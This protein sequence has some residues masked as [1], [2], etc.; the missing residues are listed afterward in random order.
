MKKQRLQTSVIVL[1]VPGSFFSNG[2]KVGFESNFV[3]KI[4]ETIYDMNTLGYGILVSVGFDN[5]QGIF[6]PSLLQSNLTIK[7]MSANLCTALNSYI[8]NELLRKHGIKSHLLCQEDIKVGDNSEIYSVK[9]AKNYLDEGLVLVCN[10]A[11]DDNTH[12]DEDLSAAVRAL[13]TGAKALYKVVPS[14]ILI[15]MCH[16]KKSN[17]FDFSSTEI[18]MYKKGFPLKGSTAEFCKS[19]NLPIILFDPF[20]TSFESI[21]NLELPS[22]GNIRI[23][24]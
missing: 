18:V 4:C 13:E 19:N 7:S 8:L 14:E 12:F 1:E 10:V 21:I 11:A 17:Y 24:V 20:L 2:K 16:I 15:A 9:L 6:E 5:I 22:A 3:N 23:I